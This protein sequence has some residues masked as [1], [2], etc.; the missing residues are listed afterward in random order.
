VRCGLSETREG[1]NQPLTPSVANRGFSLTY[2]TVC[3]A[4]SVTD[5]LTLPVQISDCHN[6]PILEHNLA[7][8]VVS[9]S[10]ATNTRVKC[11]L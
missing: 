10:F 2:F 6:I 8:L 1:T 3:G 9:Y 5:E 7:S 11:S 4:L